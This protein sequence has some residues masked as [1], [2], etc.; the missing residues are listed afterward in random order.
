MYLCR[1]EEGLL[2]GRVHGELVDMQL[3]LEGDQEGL[4]SKKKVARRAP[5]GLTG[6]YTKNRGQ[7]LRHC[8]LVLA[9]KDDRFWSMQACLIRTCCWRLTI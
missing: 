6:M 9:S 3:R 8:V 5:V 2:L 1:S 4:M 7:E